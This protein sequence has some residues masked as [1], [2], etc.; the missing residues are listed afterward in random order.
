[1]SHEYNVSIFFSSTQEGYLCINVECLMSTMSNGLKIN[2]FLQ[3]V[4][5][6]IFHF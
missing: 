3:G 2:I 4:L 1:M 5:L 6:V